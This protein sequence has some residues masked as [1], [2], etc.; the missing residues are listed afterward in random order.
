M[1]QKNVLTLL[2][3]SGIL[4]FILIGLLAGAVSC[5]DE[6]QAPEDGAP[7]IKTISVS[8]TPTPGA[9]VDVG[10]EVPEEPATATPQ[11]ADPSVATPQPE[12]YP[13]ADGY[14]A[15][16]PSTL[17][18]GY[19][20][21][22]SVS[23]FHGVNPA[24]GRIDLRLL[25]GAGGDTVATGSG[26]VAG[27]GAVELRVPDVPE[28]IY[29]IEVSVEGIPAPERAQV[30][31]EKG[32]FVLLET[33]K[34]IYKPGQTV[35]IRLMTLD[36]D[37]KPWPSDVTVEVQDAKGIK[38]F[39]QA[40]TTDE[41]GM[42]TVDLP[43]SSEPNTGVWKVVALMD[44]RR[45]QVDVRVEPYVL[46]K[47]EVAVETTKSWVLADEK[48]EGT[49]SAEYT[50]GKPVVGEVEI[51]ASR[52][53]GQWEE[54]ARYSAGLDAETAFELPPVRYASGV[55]AAQGQG[56]VSLEVTVREKGT[57][58][59][60]TITKLLTVASGPTN[61][62]LVPE[63]AVFKPTLPLQVLVIA[64]SP[65]G[66]P[67]DRDVRVEVVYIDEDFEEF[68][69]ETA[70]VSTTG[71]AGTFEVTAPRNAVAMT[72]EASADGA[73]D[74]MLLQAGRSISGDFIHVRQITE[75]EI[76]VGD[77]IRFRIYST[78]GPGNVYYEVL[79]R[80]SV[81]F[82]DFTATQYID[83]TATQLMA[84]ASRLLVYRI[85][86]NNE[87]AADQLPFSVSADYPHSVE[88]AFS[89]TEVRPGES[90]DLNVSTQG[91]A[92]VGLAA[93]DR[94]VFVLAG[95][96]LNLQQVMDE[97][98][99]LYMEPQVELHEAWFPDTITTKG[100]QETFED[101]GVVVLTNMTVPSGEQLQNELMWEAAIA[102]AAVMDDSVEVEEAFPAESGQPPSDTSSDAGLA[103]VQRVRQ[104]FPETWLWTDLSTDESGEATLPVEAPDSITTW[105]LRAVAISKEHGLGVDESRLTVFQPFFVQPNLPYSVIR[106]EETP[107]KLALYNYLDE[108]QEIFVTIGEEDWFELLDDDAKSV[109]VA[110]NDVAGLQF[111]IRPTLL[112]NEPLT[113][114]AR[115]AEAADAV[116]KRLLV[117]PE[118]VSRETVVNL[119]L[120]GTG[121]VELASSV[122]LGAVE[123][124][125]RR[126]VA[127]TGSYLTQSIEGL[128]NL[129]Q[130]SFGCG[131]QNMILFAPNV[132]VA[133]YLRDTGQ[134]K[135]EIMA[136]A[137]HLMTTGYQRQLTYMRNDGSFSAFGQSDPEGSLWLTAFV[138][139]TFSQA[140]SLLYIDEAVLDGAAR[141]ILDHQRPDGSFEPVGFLHHQELL[142]GLR[143]NTA[144]TAFVAVA[145]M[146][147]GG[148]GAANAAVSYLEVQL[149]SIEDPYAMALTAYALEL[150][151]SASADKA[152]DKLMSMATADEDGLSW[153]DG[154]A[155]PEPYGIGV[156][157]GSASVETT[158]YATLALLERGDAFNAGRAAKW[159]TTRRNSHGGF[160][161][162]QDTVV[163]LQALAAFST[164][165]AQDVDVAVR[166]ESGDWSQTVS[167]TPGNADVLQLVQVPGNA[168]VTARHEGRGEV[169]LQY[170]VRFNLPEPE[171]T[172]PDIFDIDV[173]YD[174]SE[175]E[176]DDLITVSVDVLFDPPQDIMAGMVVLDVS[177]PTGF[178]PVR[179]TIAALVESNENVKRYEVA[180]RK[181]ILYIEDMSPGESVSFEF[182]ARARYP[183]EAKGVASRAYSYYRPEW[184]GETLS[185]G[186]VIAE[187]GND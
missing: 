38:V 114:T 7:T 103:E 42:A 78:A 73:Y 107:V 79:S 28:G 21:K 86:P 134:L 72:L 99:R 47:F 139:K 117:L 98:E 101:A 24:R 20:E 186:M 104:F 27:S 94:S 164:H 166:L 97:L 65:D 26:E 51:V 158:G 116:S 66:A 93:V 121:S 12:T 37:L 157:P 36:L 109:T 15:A 161:S 80:G 40:A 16:V 83:L 69:R 34:P 153:Q 60:E 185:A 56:N 162:T 170:V 1:I 128:E 122:P 55:P 147:A 46:P 100:A 5:G 49:V 140:R 129:L 155:I 2:T 81:L 90:L 124:S 53:V 177:V 172:A 148:G 29:T 41:Y 62:S 32:A 25:N 87:I 150:A 30:A 23:L 178:D 10:A 146:E 156:G 22:V 154:A 110:P 115:S 138:L 39:K 96:R 57:G 159:L 123:G 52:Y 137:E 91:E 6:P 112:G 19:P 145:L 59:E 108:Q 187:G 9:S 18:S 180:G 167:V 120:S 33:D 82:S 63:S 135:P 31:V 48:V 118:G 181:I 8:P 163:A 68:G 142:G 165:A 50:F 70:T 77:P 174:T 173:T 143:G 11:P 102:E 89:E 14:V 171:R 64:E 105:M 184:Q 58:Y 74:G 131:E 151:D 88:A 17:R 43:L 152:H 127:V 130:M 67:V 106:G 176:V 175:V 3:R 160:D 4:A 45:A 149:D 144:L 13:P 119:V 61:L 125:G 169:V 126:Y 95:N 136:R 179:E 76:G 54:Y 35:R 84:P 92:R 85:L 183:V 71:G 168:P 182:Q 141:W 132:F 111:K 113:V 133:K 75:G 44:D